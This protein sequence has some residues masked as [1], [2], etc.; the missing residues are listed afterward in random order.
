[1]ASLDLAGKL[2]AA[3]N[4]PA[5]NEGVHWRYPAENPNQPHNPIVT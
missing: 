2:G 3:P 1:V 4:Q 5:Y